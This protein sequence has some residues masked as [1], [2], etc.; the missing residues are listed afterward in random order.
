MDEISKD[1]YENLKKKNLLRLEQN[2]WKT[3][4][5]L[6]EFLESI[7]EYELLSF[8]ST[9]IIYDKLL[10]AIPISDAGHIVQEKANGI[11]EL[12]YE[13]LGDY[14]DLYEDY[15]VIWDNSELPAVK[16]KL[17]RVVENIDSIEAVAMNFFIISETASTVMESVKFGK[18]HLYILC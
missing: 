14:L 9:R 15:Y 6:L 12:S 4:K 2:R 1:R 8:D 10:N 13:Q 11:I 17:F 7:K 5:F 18:V 16:C 3:N